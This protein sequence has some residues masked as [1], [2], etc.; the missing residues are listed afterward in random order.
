ME[1]G[2][3]GGRILRQVT[4][5]EQDGI[6]NN[7]TLSIGCSN[8]KFKATTVSNVTIATLMKEILFL[9]NQSN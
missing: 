3:K 4:C 7:P 8:N 1:A 2:G 5:R 6:S 9:I